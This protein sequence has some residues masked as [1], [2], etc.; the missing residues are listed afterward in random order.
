[1]QRAACRHLCCFACVR[2]FHQTCFGRST[3]V[4]PDWLRTEASLD[5]QPCHGKSTELST[6]LDTFGRRAC[7]LSGDRG[8][9]GGRKVR[10]PSMPSRAATTAAAC[11]PCVSS[12]W[13][14][15]IC[16]YV[17]HNLLLTAVCRELLD[18]AVC[19]AIDAEWPPEETAAEQAH[20][21]G[22]PH[23]TLVQLALWPAPGAGSSIRSSSSCTA[24]SNGAT[25]TSSGSPGSGSGCG[26]VLLLD[27]LQLPPAAA[28]A[29][30]QAV[31]R[32]G[33]PDVWTWCAMFFAATF[34][35]PLRLGSPCIA[36]CRSAGSACR[37]PAHQTAPATLRFP[38]AVCAAIRAA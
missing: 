24:V 9:P 29:A 32:C 10:L 34:V 30:L 16:H 8:G 26:C 15:A 18:G 36:L 38:T 33:S 31:F 1:M 11:Q 22:P 3:C 27:M 23:A 17:S 19:C 35:R 21:G 6:L 25:S 14:L 28:K 37:Q 13:V 5:Q 4:F 7:A 2:G 20:R 12:R